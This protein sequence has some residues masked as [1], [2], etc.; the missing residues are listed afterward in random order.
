MHNGSSTQPHGFCHD[1]N[2]HTAYKSVGLQN[3][4]TYLLFKH[5]ITT[6]ASN[7]KIYIYTVKLFV[8]DSVKCSTNGYSVTTQLNTYYYKQAT[9]SMSLAQIARPANLINVE[10]E[11]DCFIRLSIHFK[12]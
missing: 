6:I 5:C 3:I 4:I 10:I 2:L 1:A 12:L 11:N 7:L 8:Q 9:Q